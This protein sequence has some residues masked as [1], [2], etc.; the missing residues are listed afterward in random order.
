MYSE[1]QLLKIPLWEII[2]QAD[3]VRQ[4]YA[5][6]NIEPCGI[7]NAKSGLCGNDC[8]FCAQ[9]A[10]YNTGVKVFALRSKEQLLRAARQAKE[11]GAERFSI[12]TSGAKLNA[13]EID[14]MV[15]IVAGIKDEIGIKVC[16]SLG[17]LEKSELRILKQAGLSRYHHNIE[18]S[19][20]FYP[21]VV[22]TQSFQQRIDTINRAKQAGLEVCSGGIIGLGESWQDRID[23]ARVLKDL[24]VDSSPLNFLIPISGTPLAGRDVLSCQEALRVVALFRII[25]RD[26]R[27]KLAAGKEA[28]F[29]EFLPLAFIAGANGLIVGNYLTQQGTEL[30]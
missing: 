2:F 3:K 19:P 20:S 22:S 14:R 1:K 5:C 30:V 8:R 16:A 15:E 28:V 7:V 21:R 9:S 11:N 25:L 18:T 6:G 12:V 27:I 23:M 24:G 26:K 10:K 29:G 4:E 13:F 17:L